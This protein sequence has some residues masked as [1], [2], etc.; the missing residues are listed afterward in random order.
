MLPISTK[1]LVRFTPDALKD[2][3]DAPVFL[4][5]VPT[6]RENMAFT[7]VLLEEGLT[8][9]SDVEYVETLRGA[10]I[11]CVADDE[12]PA[13]LQIVDEFEGAIE[14]AKDRPIGEDAP[15][16]G[17]LMEHVNKIVST[18]RPHYPP[19]AQIIANRVYF[20]QMA[21]YVR[22]Q[23][24][25][26]KIDGDGA[27]ALKRNF[28]RLNDDVVNA[29]EKRYGD[30]TIA[31]IG[32]R[33]VELMQPTETE[34]KNSPSPPPSPPDP[35]ISTEASEPPTGPNGRFSEFVTHAIPS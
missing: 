22:T 9:P 4:L 35:E 10:I 20:V 11:E 21:P 13:L 3:E 29:I 14:A 25:L 6:M 18:L 17:D 23:M 24:F 28:G 2:R 12:Q 1:D 33:I 15:E 34:K 19:L 26:M 30:G 31:A 8:Y 16:Q 27:P 32:N 7:R 5:K